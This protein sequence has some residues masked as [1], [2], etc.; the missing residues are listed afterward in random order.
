MLNKR[1]VTA[2]LVIGVFAVNSAGFAQN[3]ADNYNDFLHYTKIGHFDLAK[4]YAQAIL[5]SNPD[6]VE[7]LGLS[8]DNPKGYVLL[9]RVKTLAEDTEL[10]KLSGQI[11]DIIEKGKYIRRADPKVIAE[12]IRRLTGT[13]RGKL[14]AVKRLANAGE[15]AIPYMLDAMADDL[16]KEELPNIIWAL[17]R[18]GKDSVR[19]LTA[20]LRTANMSVKAE[21]IRALGK[22]GY[23]QSLAYLKYIVENDTSSEL[24]SLAGRSIDE[25]DPAAGNISAA[26]LFFKLAENYYYHTD[27]LAPKEQTDFANIWFWDASEQSLTL[28]KVDIR[29]F[30]ELMAMRACE[31][32]LKA[33]PEFGKAIGLWLAAYYKTES[34]GIEMPEYFG[35]GHAEAIVYATTAGPEYLHQALARAIEDKN[36]YIALGTIEALATTA[37]EKSL[38]YRI[39]VTQPLIEALAFD[40]RAVRFSAAIAIAAAGPKDNFSE[41]RI[42]VENLSQALAVTDDTDLENEWV[43]ENYATRA[44]M[45][46]FELARTKNHVIDLTDAQKALITAANDERPRIQIHAGRVLA[47]LDSPQAQRAIA[48]MAMEQ[49]NEKFVRIAAFESLAVSAK[50]NANKLNDEMIDDIYSLVG[51]QTADTELRSAAAVAFGSLNLTSRKVKNLILDQSKN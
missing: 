51:S 14:L 39:G 49:D 7:L 12:E 30:Y 44:I 50:L 26:K 37:G 6:P 38:L 19:P 1:I 16:R 34:V 25:I 31:W 29:Y 23:P 24:R 41:S 18:I 5:D 36:G 11:L 45:V 46:M 47:Y 42:V 4:G 40:D 10:A 8:D 9:L 21:I 17:S 13:A 28:Q 20:A 27:S 2:I 35:K 48:A 43:T 15:Y 3:L 33:D 32:A 22:V